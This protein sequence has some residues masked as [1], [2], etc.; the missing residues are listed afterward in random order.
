M[1]TSKRKEAAASLL[2]EIVRLRSKEAKAVELLEEL[3]GI[4]IVDQALLGCIDSDYPN[5]TSL[6]PVEAA[7]MLAKIERGEFSAGRARRMKG[8]GEKRA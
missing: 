5:K 6:T 8:N 3:T 7:A 4:P 2:S 1:A